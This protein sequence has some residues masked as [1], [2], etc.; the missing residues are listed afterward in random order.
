MLHPTPHSY[1][2][3]YLYPCHLKVHSFQPKGR[4][5]N[6]ELPLTG[7]GLFLFSLSKAL[8]MLSSFL[9]QIKGKKCEKWSELDS[10][11]Y[12]PFIPQ[13]AEAVA[14]HEHASSPRPYNH[15]LYVR[16]SCFN[17]WQRTT[18]NS[19]PLSLNSLCYNR[20]YF[21]PFYGQTF[22]DTVATY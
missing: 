9:F 11:F 17:T 14:F 21:C 6:W 18:L 5:L 19:L 1:L 16:S 2:I 22:L 3:L 4:G 7:S 8:L 15:V 10:I 13:D 12:F 20:C